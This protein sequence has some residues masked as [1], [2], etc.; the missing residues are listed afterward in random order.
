MFVMT[1]IKIIWPIQALKNISPNEAQFDKQ[2]DLTY[3]QILSST[4]YILLHKK[5]Y[6]M[7]LKK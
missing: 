7:K 1:Y 5:E 6:T 4:V 2:P 3:L